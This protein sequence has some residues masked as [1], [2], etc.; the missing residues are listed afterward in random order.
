MLLAFAGIVGYTTLKQG[1]G[2]GWERRESGGGGADC[3]SSSGHGDGGV[4]VIDADFGAVP[5]AEKRSECGGGD[6]GK[7]IRRTR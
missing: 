6:E 7:A 5:S 3:D 2:S 4:A 1:L